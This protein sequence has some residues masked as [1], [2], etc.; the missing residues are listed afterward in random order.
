MRLHLFNKDN[1]YWIKEA[2]EWHL[3]QITFAG[4]FEDGKAIEK[5]NLDERLIKAENWEKGPDA[6]RKLG[7][8]Y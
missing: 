3:V 5:F 8:R 6:R 4:W 2:G 1:E 7:M